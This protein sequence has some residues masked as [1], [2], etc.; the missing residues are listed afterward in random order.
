MYRP[1]AD[2]F[3]AVDLLAAYWDLLALAP[4][5]PLW[6]SFTETESAPRYHRFQQ[7]KALFQAFGLPADVVAFST[8]RFL[9]ARDPLSYAFLG[10]DIGNHLSATGDAAATLLGPREVMLVFEHFFGLQT[11][12][13]RLQ[14]YNAGWLEAGIDAARYAIAVTEAVVAD[15]TNPSR[16]V[17]TDTLG[18]L[19]DPAQRRFS[20]RELIQQ[21]GFPDVDLLDVD[22]DWM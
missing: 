14:H 3:S 15:L 7:L 10:K 13:H 19:V 6:A 5:P 17:I 12:I 1:P 20:R 8:G 11:E 9:E 2:F 4:D 18:R 22:I 21:H 16:T